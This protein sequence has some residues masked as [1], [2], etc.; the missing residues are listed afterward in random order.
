MVVLTVLTVNS[1]LIS[2]EPPRPNPPPEFHGFSG[3]SAKRNRTQ[4]SRVSFIYYCWSL[5]VYALAVVLPI[6]RRISSN[7]G[8][9][10]QAM[11]ASAAS[12]ASN[13]SARIN[14]PHL[15]FIDVFQPCRT[16]SDTSVALPRL[17]TGRQSF[18]NSYL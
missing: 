13:T 11:D 12:A 3:D 18:I 5:S 15:L 2:I 10:N 9:I 8:P 7:N 17:T 6:S 4:T 1:L 16:W 14:G